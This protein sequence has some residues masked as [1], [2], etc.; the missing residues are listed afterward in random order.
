MITHRNCTREHWNGGVELFKHSPR[1]CLQSPSDGEVLATARETP[2]QLAV[3][4]T[5]PMP[6]M[7]S[8]AAQIKI[9]IDQDL[10]NASKHNIINMR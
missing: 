8:G 1:G 7:N 3:L 2:K 5:R 9:S 10:L 6:Q 4:A